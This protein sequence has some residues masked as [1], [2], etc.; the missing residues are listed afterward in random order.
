MK[1]ALDQTVIQCVNE[2][3]VNLNTASQ[4]LL[5]Y[6]SGLNARI[7]RQ[8]IEYR[9]THGPFTSRQQLLQVPQIGPAVFEQAAGFLRLPGAPHPLDNTSVHPER[10]EL[11]E[12]MAVDLHCRIEDLIRQ[13]EL[14]QSLILENYL[15]DEVGMPTLLDILKELEKPEEIPDNQPK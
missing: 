15:T 2:V 12:K 14:R 7:A 10:Y 13:Q 6:I 3:G 11:V 8:I 1:A 5:R 4:Y 9:D